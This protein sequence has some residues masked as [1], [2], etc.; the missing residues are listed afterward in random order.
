V[1]LS[2]GLPFGRTASNLLF[3]PFAVQAPPAAVVAVY[4]AE[5]GL[6]WRIDLSNPT[7]EVAAGEVRVEWRLS[8]AA[9]NKDLVSLLSSDSLPNGAITTFLVDLNRASPELFNAEMWIGH[10]C[11]LTLLPGHTCSFQGSLATSLDLSG[12]GFIGPEDLAILLALWSTDNPIG[13]LDLS[14]KVDSGDISLLLG[15]WSP[16]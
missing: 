8:E 5:D 15:A 3:P 9:R 13:D 11:T 12:D 7:P 1:P 14:G 10:T 16:E 6:S 4:I 2:L